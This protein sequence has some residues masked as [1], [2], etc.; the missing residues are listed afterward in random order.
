MTEL[1]EYPK[2]R[3][4]TYAP[5]ALKETPEGRYWRGFRAPTLLQQVRAAR[6]AASPLRRA[7]FTVGIPAAACCVCCAR[8]RSASRAHALR[9]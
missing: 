6:G 7:A 1:G 8:R 5:R 2:L 3:V 9:R 4:P